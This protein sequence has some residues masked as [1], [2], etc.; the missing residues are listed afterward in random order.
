MVSSFSRARAALAAAAIGAFLA[1]AAH[2]P[3]AFAADM[4]F[5]SP[6]PEPVNDQ[7]V[8]FG[9]GWYLRGDI[10]AAHVNIHNFSGVNL[11]PRFPNTWTGGLGAGYQY[12]NWFRTDLSFD[13]QSLY[14]KDGGTGYGESCPV[15]FSPNFTTTQT[16]TS[17]T[18]TVDP[19]TGQTT[20]SST[21]IF[22][23]TQVASSV[24]QGLCYP[25]YRNRA[26][27]ATVLANAYVDL[28]NWWGLTPYVGAGA[29]VNVMYQKSQ[30]N[31]TFGNLLPYAGYTLT[32]PFTNTTYIQNRDRTLSGTTVRFAYAFM[33]GV[34]Y[35]VTNHL[36]VDVGY[37][38]L[39][40]GSIE[41]LG[42]YGATIK[43]DLISHQVRIGFRYV[44]D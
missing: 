6:P 29:G 12:N 32:D 42:L 37:R 14:K 28:G 41:G 25:F 22:T 3:M 23:T 40:L 18:T 17:T 38:W 39:N 43:K 35:D 19:F 8:E 1:P 33:G 24:I 9:A 2:S 30:V 13:Y 21:P 10:G 44:I 4:S 26:E 34:A 36:K 5:F 16:G 11:S 27:A 7:P 31:Y 20:T 15:G